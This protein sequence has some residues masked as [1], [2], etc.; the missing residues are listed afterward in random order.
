[1]SAILTLPQLLNRFRDLK[2]NE[3]NDTLNIIHTHHSVG[4]EGGSLTLLQV[5]SLLQKGI[6]LTD[7]SL[8]DQLLIVDYMSALQQVRA[9]AI[10]KEPLNR[11]AL[12]SIASTLM[13]QTGGPIHSLLSQYNSNLGEL[14][15]DSNMAGKRVLIDAYKLPKAIDN[16]LKEVNSTITRVRTPRQIYDLS[17]EAHFKLLTL[18]PFGEGNGQMAR[19]LM[20]YIQQFHQQP[21][22]L[23]YID[24]RIHYMSA[25]EVSW[26][27]KTPTP[28]MSFMHSQLIR[29]LQECIE[30]H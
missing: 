26:R 3:A 4:V 13:R 23:V 22:S 9:M 14:R 25:L 7:K 18:H 29:F 12:Q 6:R 15:I 2:A 8:T 24:S 5:Q 27:Q 16:L 11:I 21:I 17:F 20:N 1:M 19:L 10:Q 28:I 30:Q